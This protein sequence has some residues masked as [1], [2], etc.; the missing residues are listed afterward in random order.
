[1]ND[2][3]AHHPI[4][5]LSD[6]PYER[7][8]FRLSV[9]IRFIQDFGIEKKEPMEHNP[10]KIHMYY[11]F[12]PKNRED[13]LLKRIHEVHEVPMCLINKYDPVSSY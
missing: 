12:H 8:Y 4:S 7:K 9:K 6:E 10:P 2:G 13:S 11:T 1:M 5:I 3:R